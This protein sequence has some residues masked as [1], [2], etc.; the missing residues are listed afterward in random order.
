VRLGC[1]LAFTEEVEE[2]YRILGRLVRGM[3]K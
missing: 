1:T 3:G 2:A